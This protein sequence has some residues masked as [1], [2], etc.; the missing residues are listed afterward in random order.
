MGGSRWYYGYCGRRSMGGRADR[1]E[2]PSQVEDHQFA[3]W[4]VVPE[5]EPRRKRVWGPVGPVGQQV[6]VEVE[7]EE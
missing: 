4:V 3:E 6:D 5:R 2:A 7:D 1:S